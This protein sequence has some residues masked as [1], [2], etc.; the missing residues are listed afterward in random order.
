MQITPELKKTHEYFHDF[1]AVVIK[2]KDHLEVF[3]N[4]SEMTDDEKTFCWEYWDVFQADA[5]VVEVPKEVYVIDIQALT[6][7]ELEEL[8]R[9]EF[10]VELDRRQSKDTLIAQYEALKNN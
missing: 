10:D 8:V 9:E 5:P 3:L 4:S 7:R 6:K 2:N 1:I